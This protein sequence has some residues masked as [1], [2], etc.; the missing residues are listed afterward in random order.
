MAKSMTLL[1]G[2]G[3]PPCWRVMIALEEKL[4]QGY[5]Q[6]LVSF[7][8][9]DHRS[10][11]VLDINPRAQL[12]AFKHGDNILNESYAAVLYLESQ[13]RS[14]GTPL[15][16]EGQAEQALMY[17]RMFEGQTLHQKLSD[18]VYYN[19]RVPEDERHDSTIKRNKET[20]TAELK[21]WEEYLE[22]ME[23][24]SYLA[25]RS[26][27][28]VDVLVFPVVAYAV[29]FGMSQEKYS[30]L[31]AYYTMLKDRPS[32]KATWPPHW[33]EGPGSDLIKDL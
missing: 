8:K 11:E 23:P 29:R 30:R 10:K 18:I 9:G 4:L 20:L 28:L 12:P 16:P 7:G 15:I 21:I 5:N 24:G 25:G 32:I 6:K 22:K 3:S 1:W 17:Q 14:Q 19:L 31:G 33:L 2:S 13:F 26:F 27:S